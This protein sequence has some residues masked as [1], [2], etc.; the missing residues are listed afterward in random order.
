[1]RVVFMGT[2]DFA[3][4]SLEALLFSH[5]VVAVYTRPDAAKGRGRHVTASAVKERA[6][7]AGVAVQQ[8]ASLRGPGVIAAVRDLAP[9]MI[10]VA[11][12]GAILPPELIGIPRSGCINVHASLLPRWRGAAPIERAILAGDE[13]VGVSIMQMEEGLDTG[14]WCRQAST[15]VDGKDTAELTAELA[16]LGAAALIQTLQCV[17]AGGCVWVPQDEARATYAKK[18]TASDVALDPGLSVLDAWRR[19]RA[20][21]PSAPCRA[22][23][24]GRRATILS[25]EPSPRSAP[26][27]RVLMDGALDLGLADGALRVTTLVPEG[28]KAVPA[29]DWLHG[30]RLGP[31]ATWSAL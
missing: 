23:I 2:P 24:D 12:F 20:S 9:D 25:A 3:V 4:P 15:T 6:L 1:V 8:P 22:S 16:R 21:G 17:A 30:A 7:Q 29:T 11:A 19:V 28:R 27:E 14:P 5:E 13:L 31:D 10:V 18:L 26:S